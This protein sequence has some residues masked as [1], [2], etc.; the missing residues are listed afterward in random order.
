MDGVGLA[1]PGVSGLERGMAADPQVLVVDDSEMD[2][3]LLRLAFEEIGAAATLHAVGDA[4]G[5]FAFLARQPPFTDAP[6]PAAI[7]LDVNMPGLNGFEVLRALRT[8]PAWT[9]IPVIIMTTSGSLDDRRQARDGGATAFVRKPA[10]WEGLVE[11][12]RTIRRCISTPDDTDAC[13]RTLGTQ[14]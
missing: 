14:E 6:S 4:E 11:L 3:R 7:L 1:R 12:A 9:R 8:T 13:L 10:G 5:C 2:V